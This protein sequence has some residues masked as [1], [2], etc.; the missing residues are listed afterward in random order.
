[1]IIRESNK[2]RVVYLFFE[3]N[4]ETG[5]SFFCKTQPFILT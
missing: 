2:K 3:E 4:K 1:M 5:K